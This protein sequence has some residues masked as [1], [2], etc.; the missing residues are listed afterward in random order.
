[1]HIPKENQFYINVNII[2]KYAF[3]FHKQKFCFN[4]NSDLN[5]NVKGEWEKGIINIKKNRK[6]I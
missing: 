3:P 2:Y 1:M 4:E 6:N 5:L